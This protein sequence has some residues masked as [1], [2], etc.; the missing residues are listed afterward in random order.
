M[1]LLSSRNP[2]TQLSKIGFLSLFAEKCAFYSNIRGWQVSLSRPRARNYSF[3]RWIWQF[4]KFT[5]VP[6]IGGKADVAEACV[7]DRIWLWCQHNLA[8]RKQQFFLWYRR[9]HPRNLNHRNFVGLCSRE[10]DLRNV[11]VWKSWMLIPW[12][13]Y[14]F[15][16]ARKLRPK[17]WGCIAVLRKAKIMQNALRSCIRQT[18]ANQPKNGENP[19]KFCSIAPLRWGINSFEDSGLIRQFRPLLMV[20]SEKQAFGWEGRL[21]RDQKI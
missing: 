10:S 3:S 8:W 20:L 16:N 5:P 9:S 11:P 18:L 15:F 7:S 21:P 19:E 2:P 6:K 1:N 12:A 14:R 17:I 4:W 13:K